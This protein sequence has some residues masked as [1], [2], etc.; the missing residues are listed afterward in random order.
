M[1]VPLLLSTDIVGLHRSVIAWIDAYCS[2][3]VTI[4]FETY[5]LLSCCPYATTFA[6]CIAKGSV[7][8]LAT[9]IHGI[10]LICATP[11]Q[12]LRNDGGTLYICADNKSYNAVVNP[13]VIALMTSTTEAPQQLLLVVVLPWSLRDWWNGENT[14]TSHWTSVK[15]VVSSSCSRRHER[16]KQQIV[17]KDRCNPVTCRH[18]ITQIIIFRSYWNAPMFIDTILAIH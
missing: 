18:E 12:R 1:G 5:R 11:K 10:I 9:G 6:V 4:N 15:T 17:V 8:C 7:I 2:C 13:F 16:Q 14:T 3:A